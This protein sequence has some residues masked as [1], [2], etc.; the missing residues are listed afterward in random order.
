MENKNKLLMGILGATVGI[1]LLANLLMPVIQYQTDDE[2]TYINNGSLFAVVDEDTHTIETAYIDGMISIKTDGM[3]CIVPTFYFDEVPLLYSSSAS[4]RMN[5][6]AGVWV[7]GMVSVDGA[8]AYNNV[9]RATDNGATMTIVIENGSATITGT[10]GTFTIENVEYFISSI[11]DM[12][13]TYKPMINRDSSIIAMSGVTT[14]PNP[15]GGSTTLFAKGTVDDLEIE[16]I[17][18]NSTMVVDGVTSNLVNVSTN[19]Y[20]VESVQI[21]CSQSGVTWDCIYTYFL[22]PHIV[23]YTNPDANNSYNPILL[24]IPVI[25][26]I[27]LLLVVVQ[28][29]RMRDN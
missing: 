3:D 14:N 29:V 19:L 17:R 18:T 13:L 25:I 28:S 8:P 22:A 10:K 7:S 11:G 9:T 16:R 1:I 21:E 6:G 20:K 26:I 15:P 23:K 24:A 4:V 12:A 5:N 2:R 27:A